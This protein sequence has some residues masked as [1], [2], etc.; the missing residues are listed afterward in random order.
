MKHGD[1][2]HDKTLAS[3]FPT[4]GLLF[5]PLP[6]LGNSLKEAGKPV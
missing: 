5:N 3:C 2:N 6:T 1:R 4:V